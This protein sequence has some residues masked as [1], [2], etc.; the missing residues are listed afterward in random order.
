MY[1]FFIYIYNLQLE[2][3]LAKRGYSVTCSS[4]SCRYVSRGGSRL[5]L[6]KL[7]KEEEKDMLLVPPF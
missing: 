5:A 6:Q 1:L 3:I 7:W 2:G 4:T